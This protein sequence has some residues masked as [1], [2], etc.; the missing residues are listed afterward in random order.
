MTAA[1]PK[2]RVTIHPD[3]APKTPS[4][5]LVHQALQP[6]VLTVEGGMIIGVRQPDVLAQY[7]L[8]EAVGAEAASNQTY[9]Q[10]I[11]P[12]IYI[13]KINGDEV[14]LPASKGEVRALLKRLGHEGMAALNSWYI[15]NILGPTMDAIQAAEKQA[16][17]KN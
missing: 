2:A 16:R 1:K 9:M 11:N 7:D 14:Y 8:V 5:R 13:D 10:M 6:E 17:V 3:A 15:A 12:L 4:E